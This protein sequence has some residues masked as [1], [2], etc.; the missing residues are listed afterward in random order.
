MTMICGDCC[1]T[2]ICEPDFR[3]PAA[4]ALARNTCTADITSAACVWYA[5]PNEVVQLRFFARLSRT[6]GN[7]VSAFTL[8]SHDWAFTPSI[9]ALPVRLVFIC[10]QFSA[11]VIW[12]G[13][14]AAPRICATRASGY[15]A[16][17]ATNCCNSSAD[18]GAPC[19]E[20]PVDPLDSGC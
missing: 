11:T 9:N 20:Y 19:P 6:E 10:S 4:C 14:V 18:R 12:S 5:S 1:T 3:L 15:S 7:C 2:V 13:K 17:G 8:G 16:M